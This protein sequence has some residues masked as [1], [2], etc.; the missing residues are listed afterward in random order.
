MKLLY[1]FG[2]RPEAIKLA[3][4]ITLT[5]S[6]SFF[7]TKICVTGQHSTMLNSV[8]TFFGIEP[9]YDLAIMKP[10]QTLSQITTAVL[11]GL[12]EVFEEWQPDL[13]L[14][15]GDTTTTLAASL[16]AFYNKIPIAHIEAGLRANNIMSPYPEEA[17][18]RLTSV[19]TNYHFAPTERNRQSLLKENVRSDKV[20]VTGNTVIDALK[21]SLSLLETSEQLNNSLIQ[22]YSQLDFS[23]KIVLVT[24]HRRENFG[25]GIINIC[26]ALIKIS[27]LDDVQIVYPVHLNPNIYSV[28]SSK[29]GTQKNIVLLEPLDYLD[30]VFLLNKC[31]I[32]L[33]DS[34][35]VQE[36]APSLNK[37]V[38]VMRENT[39][40]PEAVEAGTAILVGT[41][42]QR[43][44]NTAKMLLEDNK[45]TIIK[46]NPYGDGFAA[47]RIISILKKL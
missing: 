21:L 36:E 43:I 35:G 25:E 39:E 38:L 11:K 17:N 24:G 30:F 47:T 29:L 16:S 26:D 5:T 45:C 34:G 20:F 46:D 23:K 1:I 18:R 27:N 44:Y 32:V 41:D 13:V 15:H 8:L 31:T 22:K 9:D 19:L 10:N 12:D 28:V 3:P 37:P 40:R 7:S 2:T 6:D 42:V 33:T 14:V 4:L